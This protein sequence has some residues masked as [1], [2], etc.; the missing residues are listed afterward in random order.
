MSTSGF[1][2]EPRRFEAEET[3]LRSVD[4]VRLKIDSAGRILIPAEMR[5]A[6][7]IK[8]GDTVTAR[9]E[10][11]EFRIVSP[12]VALKRVQA[13]A[14]KWKAEHPDEPSVV[15]ELIAERREEARREDERYDRLAKEGRGP[16]PARSRT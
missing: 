11:G 15:D 7:M 13:F 12:D 5:A 8:P 3:G 10:D 14:R 1:A 6:M 2:E 9:V 16:V 4:Y